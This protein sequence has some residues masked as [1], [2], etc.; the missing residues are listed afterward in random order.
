MTQQNGSGGGFT[1]APPAGYQ[2]PAQPAQQQQPPAQQQVPAS[3]FGGPP[4]GGNPFG[5]A[6]PAPVPGVSL[7]QALTGFG[8]APL[9]ARYPK[10]VQPHSYLLEIINTKY[11]NG[12]NV[13][14]A[15]V[16]EAK[17]LQSDCPSQPA[18]SMVSHI[19]S[20]FNN[21]DAKNFAFSDLKVFMLATLQHLGV[22]AQLPAEA[23]LQGAGQMCAQNLAAGRRCGAQASHVTST[24]YPNRPPKLKAMFYP[25]PA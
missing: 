7:E 21:P 13:G 4:A 8:D 25:M 24:K 23:W 16:I 14:P 20:G 18:G 19:I 1:F 11:F 12:R 3:P 22:H 17:V 5:G 9:D 15:I 2:Q 6:A 10:M